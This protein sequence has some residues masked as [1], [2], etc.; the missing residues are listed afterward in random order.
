MKKIY[1]CLI[2]ATLLL[3]TGCV[4]SRYVW[5]NYD[6]K[7]YNHYKSPE[8]Y[9]QFVDDLK[10]VIATSE[11]SHRV[12]PG[13]YAEY[14]YALYESGNVL[15]AVEYFKKEQSQWPE[16]NIL[17]E[18]MISNAQ[19]RLAQNSKKASLSPTDQPSEV[20]Q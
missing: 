19:V 8:N 6:Q 2:V 10:A 5:D 20:P 14:G 13:I 1:C 3:V 17:M 11:T 4:Q 15:E 18:K 16:S 7:L 9:D 12:P